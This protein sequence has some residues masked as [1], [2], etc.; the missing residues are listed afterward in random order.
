MATLPPVPVEITVEDAAFEITLNELPPVTE[1]S[2]KQNVIGQPRGMQALKMGLSIISDGYNIFVSGEAGTGRKTAI[3]LATEQFLSDTKHLKDIVYVH[4]FSNPKVPISIAFPPGEGR[5]FSQEMEE[6]S[7]NLYNALVPLVGKEVI[8]E[9]NV[10]ELSRPLLDPLLEKWN[11]GKP[12]FYLSQIEL[13]LFRHSYLFSR[14]DFSTR[15]LHSFLLR[16]TVNVLVDQGNTLRR[17]L[18]FEDHPTFSN[19]FGSLETSREERKEF[20]LPFLSVQ[21]GSLLQ[22]AGGYLVINAREMFTVEGLY[23]ALKRFLLTKALVIQNNSS[24][25][26]SQSG[27]RPEPIECTVKIIIMGTPE[28]YENL[29][30]QDPDFTQLF[31]VACEFD[32]SMEMN[33]ENIAGTVQFLQRIAVEENLLPIE[34]SA[35]REILRYS[36]LI[37]ESR[38]ELSTQLALLADLLR[39][40]EYWAREHGK[41]SVS[42]ESV[43]SA[44]DAREYIGSLSEARIQNEI[45]TGEVNI[46]L[47]GYKT[48][49][50]NGLAVIDLGSVSFG[51]PAV[52]SATVAPGSEGI[53]NIEHEAGLSGE[54]HDKGLLIL[55]G[56]L[57]KKYARTF[58]LSIYSGICFEQSYGEVDGDSASSSELYVLLSA[59]GELPIKQN[60]AVTG[61][62]NQMGELQPVG[63][64]NEKI[65]GFYRVCKALGDIKHPGV[66]IPYQNVRNLILSSEIISAIRNREFHIYPV[67]T[68]DEGMSVLTER[69]MGERN[70][71]GQFPVDS[72]NRTI[73]NRLK[74]LYDLSRPQS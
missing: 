13:D 44:I 34:L 61:S 14:E 32:Y 36:A 46:A 63:G 4:N 7:S 72:F 66:I 59:I 50:V 29:C 24:R 43:I 12:Q 28:V 57:R 69:P 68:I 41:Q 31:K 15:D 62:V 5:T 18:I 53:V 65:T 60:I 6:F 73:E 25:E 67:H 48:G 45:A 71:K 40:S 38:E 23:E 54:I 19:L 20:N 22:A 17:P 27:I 3:T 16:Y 39:E 56:Y 70:Q 9:Q 30:E 55:E 10:T 58:P 42:E 11:E 49:V 52:I 8:S 64:I 33:E 51:T 21:A 35:Y 74:Y 2:M 37:A 1:E 47:S 26:N